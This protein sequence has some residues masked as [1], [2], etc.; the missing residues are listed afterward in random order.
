MTVAWQDINPQAITGFAGTGG[1]SSEPA[2]AT[3][4]PTPGRIAPPVWSP[5]N[6]LFWLA[7]VLAATV[8]LY[9]VS[10][11]AKAGPAKASV[12]L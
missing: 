3:G 12:S 10:V 4:A 11:T 6:P 2:L 8:G 5:D 1:G 7:L 9:A